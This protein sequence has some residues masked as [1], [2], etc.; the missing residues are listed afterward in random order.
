MIQL[1]MVLILQVDSIKT[2]GEIAFQFVDIENRKT[3]EKQLNSIC[4]S[5]DIITKNSC[6]HSSFV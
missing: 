2:Q 5:P 3:R 4:L 6:R 1:D